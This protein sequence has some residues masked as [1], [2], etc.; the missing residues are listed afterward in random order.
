MTNDGE[1]RPIRYIR[2]SKEP[3]RESHL[4]YVQNGN[5]VWTLYHDPNFGTGFNQ[6]V[7]YKI[8]TLDLPAG[9]LVEDCWVLEKVVAVRVT[10]GQI[11]FFEKPLV[12][13]N[14]H[15]NLTLDQSAQRVSNTSLVQDFMSGAANYFFMFTVEGGFLKKYTM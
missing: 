5:Q 9:V 2:H 6:V 12:Q 15:S 13:G 10:G 1:S 7:K 11:A 14:M 4:T 3:G 8:L